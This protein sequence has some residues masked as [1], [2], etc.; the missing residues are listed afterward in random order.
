MTKAQ[1]GWIR[2]YRAAPEAGVQV[3]CLPHAGGSATYFRPMAMALSPTAEVL[4]VQYPGR[5]DRVDEPHAG[6]F[7]ELT[8]RTLAAVRRAADRPVALFGHSMG[9]LLAFQVARRLEAEGV[10]PLALFAS[11]AQPPGRSLARHTHPRTDEELLADL[12]ML[13]GTDERLLDH[14]DMR[15]LVLSALR[16]DYRIL[17]SR[18]RDDATLACPVV[19]LTGDR[20]PVV[21]VDDAAA[22]AQHTT[23]RFDLHVFPGEHFY[24]DDHWAGVS[25]VV[26]RHLGA[27]EP[28]P[29]K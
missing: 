15:G 6:D 8:E 16:A 24:L 22:W 18:R 20:D 27:H 28:A 26:T 17:R 11:G 29:A 9:A 10:V 7:E 23:G 12:A 1:G 5:M 25:A 3:V 19:S 13:G 4:A 21:A 2:R 14:P